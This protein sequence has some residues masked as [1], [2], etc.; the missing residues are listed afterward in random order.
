MQPQVN[1]PITHILVHPRLMPHI[2]PEAVYVAP[3]PVSRI[4]TVTQQ[5]I[6]A[7]NIAKQVSMTIKACVR[8]VQVTHIV[9]Q[10]GPRRA[11]RV[12]QTR[13]VVAAHRKALANNIINATKPIR[14]CCQPVHRD[15]VSM[16]QRKSANCAT[17]AITS[18]I[19]TRP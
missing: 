18:T 14:A 5:Q 19:I 3:R 15:M 1:V 12:P 16:P 10:T 13:K 11:K 8:H 7:Q 4:L 9:T 17:S 6:R 2:T